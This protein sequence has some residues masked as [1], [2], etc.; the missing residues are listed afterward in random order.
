MQGSPKTGIMCGPGKV[1]VTAMRGPYSP[2]S[3]GSSNHCQIAKVSIDQL[4]LGHAPATSVN[5]LRIFM[6]KADDSAAMAA[7]L[8]GKSEM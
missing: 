7:N 4:K 3:Y 1:A 6:I 5:V 8:M 2:R